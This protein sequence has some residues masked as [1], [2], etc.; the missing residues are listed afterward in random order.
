M[1]V[2][3]EEDSIERFEGFASRYGP[4]FYG[5]PVNQDEVTLVREEIDIPDALMAAGEE[6]VP[7]HAG[8]KL[9]WRLLD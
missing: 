9:G 6:I 1:T 7:F 8:K 4:A 3:E 2:F 5:L